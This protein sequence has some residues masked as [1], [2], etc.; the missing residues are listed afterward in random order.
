MSGRTGTH[1]FAVRA[2]V[3]CAGVWLGVRRASL[4]MHARGF[5]FI[6]RVHG[7]ATGRPLRARAALAHRRFGAVLLHSALPIALLKLPPGWVGSAVI[8]GKKKRV[9]PK[10][11]LYQALLG[12]TGMP[13]DMCVTRDS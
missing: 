1:A 8:A 3:L 5:A 2:A 4:L 7:V 11:V 10:G 6:C 12:A 13:A 9:D